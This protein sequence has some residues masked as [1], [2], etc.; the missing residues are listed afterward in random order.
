MINRL[1]KLTF[2]CLVLLTVFG[3]N[4]FAL[5]ELESRKQGIYFYDDV[6]QAQQTCGPSVVPSASAV[7]GSSNAEVAYN[8]LLSVGLTPVQAAGVVGNLI[9]ES[10]LDP[11]REETRG[12]QGYFTITDPSRI[13]P[14]WG[15][16]IAQWTTPGRQNAWKQ[17]AIDN[18]GA[19]TTLLLSTELE[20][21]WHELIT[22][23]GFG[24]EQLKMA[25]DERQAAWIILSYF[26]RPKTVIDGNVVT[27]I[28]QPTAKNPAYGTLNAR[29][30]YASAVFKN[31]GNGSPATLSSGCG[32][33]QNIRT[34]SFAINSAVTVDE[35]PTGA[36]KDS[37]C[38]GSFTVGA[39]ALRSYVLNKWSPP[40]SEVQGYNC[41]PIL[42]DKTKPTSIHG[43]GRAIDIMIDST[44]P[45]EKQVGDNIRN[46]LINNATT[47]GV[48]RVIWT[49]H[50]WSANQD[51]WRVYNGSN[52]HTNHLHVEINIQASKNANLI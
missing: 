40:V 2:T 24:L 28:A 15:Y 37:N 38:T 34:P 47:L 18:G 35:S 39:Q 9:A 27:T 17:Y 42:N 11:L 49:G 31:F 23:K 22:T 14:G 20:Y 36:H 48:Q 51:G 13:K 44:I 1:Y 33:S 5:N 43:L 19:S 3:P 12:R 10:R 41:R 29:H 45:S 21:L 52:P 30:S 50:I 7:A 26:E 6:D 16:G 32:I 46:F 4:V 8:Y 25:Q